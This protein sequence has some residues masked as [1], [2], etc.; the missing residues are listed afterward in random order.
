MA[1]TWIPG[2][3]GTVTLNSDALTTTGRVT[4][5]DL[6]KGA[7]AKPV[8][9]AQY[10]RSVTGS[11][12]G[13]FSAEGHVATAAPLADLFDALEAVVPVAF[14]IQLGDAAGPTDGGTLGGNCNVTSLQVS[15]D[16][17]GEW[18]WAVTAMTDGDVTYTAPTP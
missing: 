15:G 11:I 4:S 6:T 13:T 18:D 10:Q 9:G 8:F 5:L 3:L 12:S 16:A 17:E 1:L 14:L 7:N 2:Y